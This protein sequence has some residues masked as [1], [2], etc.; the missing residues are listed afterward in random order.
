MKLTLSWLKDHLDTTAD[1]KTIAE[2]LTPSE[3][4]KGFITA[5]AEN[6]Q[7]HP[8]SDHLHILTVDTGKEKLQVVCGAPNVKEGMISIF[9]PVGTLIPAYNEILKETKIRGVE[10]FGM[11]CSEIIRALLSLTQKHRSVCLQVRF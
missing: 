10:S 8:D 4:L 2:T 7:M 5:K 1:L 9:A 6:V 3:N 11:L